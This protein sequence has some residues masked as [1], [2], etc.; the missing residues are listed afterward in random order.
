MTVQA[1]DRE[2]ILSRRS[3]LVMSS[4]GEEPVSDEGKD[5]HSI[6]AY[7]LISHLKKVDDYNTGSQLFE[8]IRDEVSSQFPQQPQLGSIT[9][10]GHTSGGD[11]LFEINQYLKQ[12]IRQ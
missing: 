3:V 11:Y 8:N 12:G 9:S 5:G 1:K 7:T 6:F 10:A 2:K 4:G